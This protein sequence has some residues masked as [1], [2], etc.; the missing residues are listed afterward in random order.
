[1]NDEHWLT[2][3]VS[4]TCAYDKYEDEIKMVQEQWPQL[5]IDFLLGYNIKINIKRGEIN[6][7]WWGV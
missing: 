5:K 6:L 2:L 1:M 4:M 7:R 3:K